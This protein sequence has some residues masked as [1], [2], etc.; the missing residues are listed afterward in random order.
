[1][2]TKTYKV[3]DD[4]DKSCQYTIT[5]KENSAGN[6]YTLNRSTDPEWI[7]PGELILSAVDNGNGIKF[8]KKQNMNLE[9][10]EF[11]ELAILSSFIVKYDR[12]LMG[13]VRIV[14]ETNF[15]EL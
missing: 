13:D 4:T 6:S 15:Y 8:S 1:M 11:S 5:V 9:Y 3:F 10:D 7:N 2:K 12:N 14:E